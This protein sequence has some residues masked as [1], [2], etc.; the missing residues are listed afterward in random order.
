MKLK[1][2]SL[3]SVLALCSCVSNMTGYYLRDLEYK[4]Y[5]NLKDVDHTEKVAV[6]GSNY[7][8]ALPRYREEDMPSRNYDVFGAFILKPPAMTDEV[9]IMQ[10]PADYADYLTGKA[11]APT[12]PSF[13]KRAGSGEMLKD[14]GY[15]VLPVVNKPGDYLVHYNYEDPSGMSIYDVVNY[16]V[17]DVVCSVVGTALYIPLSPLFWYMGSVKRERKAHE[18]AALQAE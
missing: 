16:A 18:A 3:V 17:G 6:I 4:A 10:I 2:L 9:D 7:Y 15:T 14:S 5:V 13:V 11:T 1:I 8:L 12:T